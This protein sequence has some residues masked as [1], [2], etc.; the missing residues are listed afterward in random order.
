MIVKPS[1]TVHDMMVTTDEATL[2]TLVLVSN[3]STLIVFVPGIRFVTV[4]V[5]VFVPSA[6][7]QAFEPFAFSNW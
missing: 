6:N 3:A 2:E 1:G 4:A 7:C 5:Q